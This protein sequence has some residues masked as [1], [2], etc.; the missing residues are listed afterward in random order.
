MLRLRNIRTVIKPLTGH[1]PVVP[2]SADNRY[3]GAM[4]KLEINCPGCGRKTFWH[5]NPSRPFC[6]EKCRVIDLGAWA[7]EEYSV[8]GGKAPQP[9]QDF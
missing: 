5:D 1:M 2:F 6:S 3:S 7:S 9:E 8:D 4:E